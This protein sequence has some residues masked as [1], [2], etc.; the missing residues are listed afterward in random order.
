MRPALLAV[1]AA[2]VLA[3]PAAAQGTVQGQALPV[4][5]QTRFYDQAAFERAI[6]PYA[7]AIARNASDARAH[8]WL[9]VAY[10]HMA[11]FHRFGLAPYAAD[12]GRR[13]VASLERALSLQPTPEV[14]LALLD[15]YTLVGDVDKH[16]ALMTRLAALGRPLA[17][18]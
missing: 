15:A 13:A 2:A 11:R 10:L 17:V 8:Y 7:A 14:M 6:A 4:F 9:G 1:L 12:F 5:D 16:R 3:A 18:R